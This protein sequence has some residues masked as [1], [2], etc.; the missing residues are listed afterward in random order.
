MSNLISLICPWWGG[1]HEPLM[2]TIL[3][4]KGICDEAIVVHQVLFDED[5]DVLEALQKTSPV[6]MKIERVN[7]NTV[8]TH[9]FGDLANRNGQS[10]CKWM[11]LL[12]VG[13]TIAEQYQQPIRTRLAQADLGTTYRCNH[14]G[15][16]NDWH[17]CWSPSSG[18]RYGGL[19]HE[20]VTN[21]RP[22]PIIFRMQDTEKEPHHDPF[23]NECLKWYKTC[24]YNYNYWKLGNAAQWLD[25]HEVNPPELDATDRGWLS[26][27][28]GARESIEAF[29]LEHVDLIDA[30]LAGDR[31]KFYEGVRYR[32][33]HGT[34]PVGVN[35]NPTGTPT[36][37][38]ETITL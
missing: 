16:G 36:S 21:H 33:A 8:F 9:G 27:V 25:G 28:R 22:G 11:L 14:A 38:N 17:R 19:I 4:T 2:R 31:D 12:G 1:S 7:W 24:A 18:V 3:S 32:M 35:W 26:F 13:E 30:A 5:C 15:D 23:H 6:P 29:C 34:P 20:T 37:G 10:E